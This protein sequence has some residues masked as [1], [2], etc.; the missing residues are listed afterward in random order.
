MHWVTWFAIDHDV[1]PGHVIMFFHRISCVG[2]YGG[3]INKYYNVYYK[4]YKK[5]L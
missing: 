3:K 1:A 4:M 5:L 2:P